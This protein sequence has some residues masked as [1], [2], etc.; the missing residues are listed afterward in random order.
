MIGHPDSEKND[1]MSNTDTVVRIENGCLLSGIVDRRTVGT[2]AGSLI[3]VM[4][5]ERGPIPTMEFINALNKLIG[6]FLMIYSSSI[7]VGDTI[8]SDSTLKLIEHEI[9]SAK[10][11]VA[12]SIKKARNGGLQRQPGSTLTETFEAE[13]NNLLNKAMNQAGKSVQSSLHKLNNI[14]QMVD[15][16]SKGNAINISQIIACVGQQ[17]VMGK[18]IPYGF[19]NR[20]LPHFNKGDLGPESRGFVSNSYLQGLT[21]QEMY[22]HAMGGR[23]GLVD[24]AVKTASTGYIQRR[25]IKAMEDVMVCYDRTVRNSLGHIIQFLYGEDGL[26]AVA[27]ERQTMPHI[28]LSEREFKNRYSYDL[29][30]GRMNG[31]TFLDTEVREEIRIDHGK[32][33][34]L[35]EEIQQLR[36]D[37]EFFK[38]HVFPVLGYD[39][40]LYLP[41]N[42]KRLIVNAQKEFDIHVNADHTAVI[43][44]V[45][46][47]EAVQKLC[48]L[49]VILPKVD[50]DSAADELRTEADMN[51]TMLFKML[52]RAYLASKRVCNEYRLTTDA[53]NFVIGEIK[54]RFDAAI[55]NPGEVVGTIAAQSIGEPA[56]QMTLNT[57]HFAG[58]SAK[59]VTLG[60]PRLA[61]L[62]NVAQ[63]I[64]TPS[65]T[66]YLHEDYAMDQYATKEVLNKLEYCKL[67]DIVAKTQIYYDPSPKESVVEEDR[68]FLD[69]FFDFPDADMA[70]YLT[71][72]SPWM[73][74]LV[75][76]RN[77]KEDKNIKNS[78]VA[79]KINAMWNGEIKCLFSN[80]NAEELVLQIRMMDGF[81]DDNGDSKMEY[82][83]G[84]MQDAQ[85]TFL[86]QLEGTLLDDVELR[87]IVG[88]EK[89]FMRQ[90]N[91]GYWDD[92]HNWDKQ[93][94]KEWVLDTEGSAL[95]DVMAV[96][97]VDDTR[98]ISNHIVHIFH[99][100]GIE[101]A[102]QALLNEVRTVISFD[103]SYVNYRHLAILVDTMSYQGHLMSIT[104]HG[105]NR[106]DTGPI[107]RASFEETV[108]ILLEASHFGL[109]DDLLGCS[110]N[111]L[112]G[113]LIPIGTG[114]FDLLLDD[115]M[116][117]KYAEDENVNEY[118]TFATGDEFA[119]LQEDQFLGT[120]SPSLVSPIYNKGW[121]SNAPMMQAFS[122][123]MGTPAFSP[124]TGVGGS[125]MSMHSPSFSDR[126]DEIS[127]NY[128]TSNYTSTSPVYGQIT[129]PNY[130]PMS[131]G[132]SPTSPTYRYMYCIICIHLLYIHIFIC[133]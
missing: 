33:I 51:A 7:G 83:D 53:F 98:T 45:S 89:V 121:Q 32:Q 8:A 38:N 73:L 57:F 68:E 86:R 122:P 6:E 123:N 46:V 103:G 50:M 36:K 22:F 49:I 37:R 10:R 26:D 75:L 42:I 80:D 2:S 96:E 105:I 62:I 116:L 25:L 30:N 77:K 112:L 97:E 15:A 27:I 81:L 48:K 93:K 9:A 106:R 126:Y 69:Y 64:K 74:R 107:M 94:Q 55:V 4:F 132:Y 131:P 60:V 19:S 28:L 115:Q 18:R 23:E 100:L 119:A 108:E 31:D 78:Q 110:E 84:D 129:S 127:P 95:L 52:I 5:N 24:T 43:H 88:I 67:R 44:P 133:S 13:V 47:V 20:T 29:L 109:T 63:N 11:D 91:R 71:Q 101:A 14:K 3:H 35:R 125:P 66:I 124:M 120:L 54:A 82:D 59:N 104:R 12:R 40:S 128:S 79:D 118:N 61:E 41:V 76:D 92:N 114:A 1:L 58:V 17:N 34:Q 102:R 111:I 113:Q 21:P 39:V 65:L 70:D 56:T 99:I 90:V 117:E 16:G 130:S 85:D 72:A 87:G